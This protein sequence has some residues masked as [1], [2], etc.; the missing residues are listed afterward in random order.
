MD[1]LKNSE[2][3]KDILSVF[4]E[5]KKLSLERGINEFEAKDALLIA[6]KAIYRQDVFFNKSHGLVFGSGEPISAKS[7]KKLERRIIYEVGRIA[8][9][10]KYTYLKDKLKQSGNTADAVVVS[11]IKN[12]AVVSWE[13]MLFSISGENFWFFKTRPQQGQK[14]K[15]FVVKTTLDI[16]CTI[17]PIKITFTTKNKKYLQRELQELLGV[18]KLIVRHID[19]KKIYIELLEPLTPSINERLIA[20][21]YR[22][23][24]HN[25]GQNSENQ[26]TV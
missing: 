23:Y 13:N 10:K 17:E 20:C 8:N 15:L 12:L 21:K 1:T 25:S 14:I 16:D 22:V 11:Y 18:S 5:I 4:E 2:N 7:V 9:K 6:L 3:C 19:T 24:L 26:P